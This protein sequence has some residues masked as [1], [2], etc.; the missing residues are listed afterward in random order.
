MIPTQFGASTKYREHASTEKRAIRR[1]DRIRYQFS[2]LIIVGSVVPALVRQNAFNVP[3][4]FTTQIASII[5]GALAL[6]IGYFTYRRLIVFPG[7]SAGGYVITSM[8]ASFGILVAI[9]VLCRIDYSRW[10]ITTCYF[11]SMSTLLLIHFKVE[12]HRNLVFAYVP[13]GQ[14]SALPA[15]ARV[16]WRTIE[17]PDAL[18]EGQINAIVVDL[19][20]EHDAKWESAI[21]RWVLAGTPV[22]DTRAAIEQLTGRVEINHLYENTLGSL[23]PNA[24]L[25]KF[26]SVIDWVAS[27]LIGVVLAP[28]VALIA[29]AVR[30]DSPGPALFRQLRIGFRARPFIVYKFRTM[31]VMP[32]GQSEEQIRQLAMTQND[33][34]RITRFGRWLR[35]SRLDELPQ[36]INILKG[37][38]SLI[39]PRPE[40]LSLS[41]WYEEEISFYHYRHI[42]K[43]GITGWAQVNQGHVTD[44]E[45][46]R[47]KLHLDFYYVKNYS[48]WLDILIV[49]RTVAIMVTGNGA[50]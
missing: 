28:L 9:F 12:R 45:R 8:T 19:H 41:Q 15:L 10:Q 5:G 42:I 25:I 20:H 34:Q 50:R 2:L 6:A 39:G 33:D 24:F 47:E 16:M 1:L 30:L 37:E 35:R 18:P 44:V 49:L 46:I 27:L 14:T 40:A 29:I 23:N 38:M 36:L 7:I 48:F 32:E 13:G 4:Y 21:A 26:K 3:F 17:H 31:R 22:Y 43:P 11:L